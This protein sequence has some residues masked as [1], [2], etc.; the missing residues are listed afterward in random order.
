MVGLTVGL[1]D[2]I[3]DL[4]RFAFGPIIPTDEETEAGK[5]EDGL[6]EAELELD[7]GEQGRR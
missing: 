1:L 7:S 5:Y 2:P 6:R 4:L 3:A